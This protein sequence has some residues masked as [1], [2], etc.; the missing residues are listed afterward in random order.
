M[1]I[2]RAGRGFFGAERLSLVCDA[3][4]FD[5]MIYTPRCVNFIK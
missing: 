1:T 2:F 5:D 4:C 3:V